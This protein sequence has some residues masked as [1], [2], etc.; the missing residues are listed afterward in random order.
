MDNSAKTGI[1]IIATGV[2]VALLYFGRDI[3]AP[4]AIAIFL[5]LVMESFSKTIDRAI[6]KL[7][8]WAART[9]GILL[10]VLIFGLVIVMLAR[11]IEQIGDR[12]GVYE[13]QINEIIRAA[14]GVIGLPDAPTLSSIIFGETGQRFIG[15]LASTTRELSENLILVLIYVAFLF[16]ASSSWGLKFDAIFKKDHSRETARVVSMDARHGIESYLWTQT[17]ISALTTVLTYV[18]LLILGVENAIFLSVLIFVLNYIPTI[19]SIV[20]AFVPLLFAIVQPDW[21]GWMPDSVY[22]NAFIVFGAVSFWQFVIG[23]FLQPRMMGDSLNLSA[24]VV[25]ISLAVWGALWGIAGMFLSAPLTVLLMILFNQM[26][27]T[28]WLAVLLSADGKP[29]FRGPGVRK[30]VENPK[31]ATE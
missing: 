23:N 24:L 21:P 19:G 9:I 31:S 25:L 20:A 4:L 28:R 11:G 6:P 29:G 3:L 5:W 18:T 2:I 7:P 14:Y 22:I 10:V 26:H 8:G 15:V 30:D 12:A 27:E 16:L 17:L 13:E 1:W